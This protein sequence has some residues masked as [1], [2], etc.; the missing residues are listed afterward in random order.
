MEDKMTQHEVR[1][2]TDGSVDVNFYCQQGLMEREAIIDNSLRSLG[3]LLRAT[4]ARLT[5]P[6]RDVPSAVTR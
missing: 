4:F 2:R 3:R 5:L 6:S 1:R